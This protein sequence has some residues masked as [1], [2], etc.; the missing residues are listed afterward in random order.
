MELYTPESH[1]RPGTLDT[2]VRVFVLDSHQ[3]VRAGVRSA[4]NDIRGVRIVGEAACCEEALRA[5]KE[6]DPAPDV[7]L[8]DL[9]FPD[10]ARVALVRAV[11]I[12]ALGTGV[13]PRVLVFSACG[14]DEAVVAALRAGARGFI[15]KNVSTRELLRA[16]VTVADGGAVFSPDVAERLSGYFSAMH[17]LPHRLA[18]PQLTD[19]EREILDLLARGHDNRRIARTLVLSEK[20][21]RNHVSRV[22]AKLQVTR[23]T[24]AAL[25]ARDAGL[26]R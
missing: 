14:D 2:V 16:I 26:G 22:F 17:E 12:D 20:T 13:P 5:L 24:E 3:L 6:M 7:V 11:A 9:E 23:R 18:F 8:V 1:I 15:A 19:R 4:F 10:R 21:I 25:R